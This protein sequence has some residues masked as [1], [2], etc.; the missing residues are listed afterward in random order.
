M[1]VNRK[2]MTR[3]GASAGIAALTVGVLAGVGNAV[4]SFDKGS[5][6][7]KS[8][9]AAL[10]TEGTLTSEQ[11]VTVKNALKVAGKATRTAHLK[12]LVSAGT[13]TQ[14]QA[15]ALS[16]KGGIRASVKSGDMTREEAKAL[17][18]TVKGTDMPDRGSRFAT[19]MSALVADGTITQA[20]ADA[21]T[22]AKPAKGERGLRGG[23]GGKGKS[24]V[25]ALVTEGTLTSEQAV[26]VK[27]A[28]KV[29]GKATRTAHLKT[30]VSAGTI[31]QTQA[32]ALSSK[33]GI[34][35]SVKSG[36]MTREEAKALH[37]TVKGT[38][39]PDRGS[40]FATVMSA[41]VAD[42]TIT[43]AQADAITAAK[44]SAASA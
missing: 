40:R 33:G 12:T 18:A 14:T 17:H 7:S 28:L 4:G 26:T 21:I 16:S 1:K 9:V 11:A 35:A 8:P 13:I 29:A 27:N 30:L 6:K 31:T 43:Q 5:G 42:G 20:Q 25:A 34:R 23:K 3:I 19:V 10:V 37:A 36:D 38:D 22:A 41:L 2:W 15:D 32:D 39:M 44:S 24:P